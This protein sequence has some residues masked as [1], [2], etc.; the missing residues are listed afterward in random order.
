[1]AHQALWGGRFKEPLSA[2]ALTFSSS[3]DLDKQLYQEDIEGS[4]AHVEML[5]ATRIVTSAEARRIRTALKNIQ[6]EIESG[7]FPLTGEFEDV[8][9]AIEQRLIQNVGPLGGK[10]H[11]ARSRND[12]IALDERLYLRAAIKEISKLLLHLQRVLLYKSEKH[13]GI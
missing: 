8:H 4:I 6:K 7:K 11:T 12:Q 2:I 3:I 1:M 9:M 5:A 10:L 13:F